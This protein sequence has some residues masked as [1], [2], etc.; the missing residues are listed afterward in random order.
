MNA[1]HGRRPTIDDVARKA[2]VSRGTV[3]RVL[4]GGHWVS[5]RAREQVEEAIRLTGYR[6]NP[7]ARSLATSR[8]G[9]VGFLLNESYE[10]FFAD[11]NFL[12]ILRSCADALAAHGMSVVLIMADSREERARATDFLTSGHVDGALVVSQHRDSQDFLAAMLD[13][14]LPVVSAGVPL[15]F[16]DKVAWVAADDAGGARQMTRHLLSKHGTVAHISGPL[17]TSGGI[18]RLAA[19]REELGEA[20]DE[21]L[22]VNGDYSR[23]SG[24]AG[25]RELLDRD[26]PIS[27]V[28]A[29]NDLMA[30]GAIDVLQ[31]RGIPVPET[32]AV[33]G[34]DDAPVAREVHP[35]LTT[36]R[37]ELARVGEEMARLLLDQLSGRGIARVLLPTGLVVRE[38]A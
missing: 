10:R 15:G 6:I 33:A 5:E 36:M 21:R 28:F 20:Y 24:A 4:N 3:S 11:P 38:S 25:M 2:G 18:D 34:F 17:D 16:E 7:H 30:A 9:S 8:T 32:I 31:E 29:G 13:V 19:Y 14:R 35:A 23:A 1:A 26:V 37:Q 22:V 12:L 27:A